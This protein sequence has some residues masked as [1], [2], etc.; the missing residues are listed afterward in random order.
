MN[1]ILLWP[2]RPLGR[3]ALEAEGYSAFVTGNML[4]EKESDWPTALAKFSR[5]KCVRVI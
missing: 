4:L 3:S 2:H 5:A 1:T